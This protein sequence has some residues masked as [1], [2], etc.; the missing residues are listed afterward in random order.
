MDVD[1]EI[2]SVTELCLRLIDRSGAE[3]FRPMVC[4]PSTRQLS[5][6]MDHEGPAASDAVR[7]WGRRIAPEGVEFLVAFQIAANEFQIDALTGSEATTV[8]FDARGSKK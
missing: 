3:T 8:V 4:V 1:A 7:A 2:K 5:F 6:M